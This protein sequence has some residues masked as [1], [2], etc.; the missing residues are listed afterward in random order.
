MCSVS[1]R[2]VPK[3]LSALRM[4]SSESFRELWNTHFISSVKFAFELT[5]LYDFLRESY[6][7]LPS[8]GAHVMPNV[9]FAFKLT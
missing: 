5:E 4:F 3:Y 7:F 6:N 9:K 2:Y 8:K 1:A